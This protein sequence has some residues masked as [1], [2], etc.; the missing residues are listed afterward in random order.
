MSHPLWQFSLER[1]ARPGVRDA[2]LAAQDRHAAD[3]NLLLYLAWLEQQG[4]QRSRE[5]WEALR[6]ML[7]AC[8]AA[9]T[10]VRRLRRQLSAE[11]APSRAA[12]LAQARETEL[13]LEQ[14]EQG[15]IHDWHLAHPASPAGP[16]SLRQQLLWLLPTL[17]GDRGGLDCL[18]ACLGAGD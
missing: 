12:L 3:V 11:R 13:A 6:A 18:L 8:R 16:Y 1:Y 2:C 4:L 5:D 17:V 7:Q 15:L 10:G 14:L 9:V